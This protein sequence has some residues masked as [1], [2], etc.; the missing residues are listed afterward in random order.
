MQHPT[1]DII[2]DEHAALT[3][4]LRS[5]LLLV[6]ESRRAGQAPDFAVLRAMLFYLDEFPDKRHHR[7]ESLLLFPKLRARSLRAR[8]LLDELEAQHARS[9]RSIRDLEHALLAYEMLGESRREAF[10]R[11]ARHYVDFYLSHMAIEETQVLPL[12]L[13]AFS[14][15]DWAEL[16]A[17]FAKDRETQP[18]DPESTNADYRALFSR[19]VVTAPAPVGLGPALRTEAA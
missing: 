11:S 2:R 18:P 6:A 9:E 16:D 13:K 19:I 3:A 8:P 1:L 4:M 14:R 5:I 12:A 17:A 7:K 10:E 15:E